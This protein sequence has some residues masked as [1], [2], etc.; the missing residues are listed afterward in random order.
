MTRHDRRGSVVREVTVNGRVFSTPLLD[1]EKFSPF[2]VVAGDVAIPLEC[3]YDRLDH[4]FLGMAM[5]RSE[6]T[7]PARLLLTMADGRSFQGEGWIR[8]RAHVPPPRYPRR[9]AK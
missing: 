6:Q 5:L 1:H 2:A 7:E 8:Q 9:V 3:D 4:D